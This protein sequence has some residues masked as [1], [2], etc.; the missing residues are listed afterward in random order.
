MSVTWLMPIIFLF[1]LLGCGFLTFLVLWPLGRA[2]A[3]KPSEAPSCV[4]AIA[5]GAATYALA[6]AFG[7]GI[8]VE[9]Q[10]D[11]LLPILSEPWAYAVAGLGV[12][13]SRVAARQLRKFR[14]G[15]LRA[16][17][18]VLCWGLFANIEILLALGEGPNG[19]NRAFVLGSIFLIAG[20]FT[21]L[22]SSTSASGT[23]VLDEEDSPAPS[24][25][26]PTGP[27]TPLL[28]PEDPF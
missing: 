22:A 2:L 14:F 9:G 28:P 5:A 11:G 17:A 25:P 23:V 18:V 6:K 10:I 3:T 1:I 24:P 7:L 13:T 16:S 27:S 21:A 15:A 19:P 4:L 12:F 20:G 8:R 26:T